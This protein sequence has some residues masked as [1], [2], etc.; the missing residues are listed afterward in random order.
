[1]TEQTFDVCVIGAGPAG[2]G[3]ITEWVRR[4]GRGRVLL[5]EAGTDI[6]SRFCTVQSL[7]GCRKVTPCQVTSG[8]GGASG[9]AGGK[10]SEYPAGR[11]LTKLMGDS[12][13]L[14][15]IRSKEMMADFMSL[16]SAPIDAIRLEKERDYYRNLDYELR[17]YPANKYSQAQLMSAWGDML[18]HAVSC[19]VEVRL[20]TRAASL[21]ASGDGVKVRLLGP[22]G[23]SS[24][25]AGA[26]LIATGRTGADLVQG[27]GSISAS[28]PVDVGVRI[29]FPSKDWVDMD[30]FHGDLKLHFGNART[31]C[32][33]KSG[34]I[35]PYRHK[36][37][38]LL[39]GRTDDDNKSPWSNI[40]ISVR[41]DQP[42]TEVFEHV[43]AASLLQGPG[44]SIRQPL[45]DY[46]GG[47]T[48][49]AASREPRASFSY[50][51]WGDINALFPSSI[52]DD[53]R[54]AV[55]RFTSEVLPPV[56]ARNAFVF[57]PEIDYY[58]DTL[59]HRGALPGVWSA[60][61][62]TGLYRGTLQAYTAGRYLV[63]E[64]AHHLALEA[65]S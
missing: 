50:W 7:R 54:A 19:G 18:R 65:A 24:V 47:K 29:E 53:I 1:M 22:E 37:I 63:D 5:V 15:L 45:Q 32:A 28:H 52:G 11:A 51:R 16:S 42:P 10:L 55:A 44:S 56:A 12:A 35:S 9:L 57:G 61:D 13:E 21:E 14:E 17:H 20:Q 27:V 60:G 23:D 31:F 49:A 41:T 48:T 59:P 38:M 46:L 36:D 2:L 6:E 26:V 3:F 58:W 64:V 33:S 8:V 30:A 39:E 4:V 25:Q 34:W 62:V 40:A 43:R